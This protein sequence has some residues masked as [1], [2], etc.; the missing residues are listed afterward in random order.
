MKQKENQTPK[1]GHSA[2]MLLYAVA[3]QPKLSTDAIALEGAVVSRGNGI[4]A[5][6]EL[7]QEED[8]TKDAKKHTSCSYELKQGEIWVGNTDVR[9]GLSIPKYLIG[10][11]KTARLGEQAY[12]IDGKPIHRKYCRP[13]IIHKSEELIYDNIMMSRMNSK[14]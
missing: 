12:Y 5:T 13:L 14:D 8:F 4:G 3:P 9:E 6:L 1:Q 10:K 7:F 2:N 11:M